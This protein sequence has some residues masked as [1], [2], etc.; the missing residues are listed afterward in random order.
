ML[1]TKHFS[2]KYLPNVKRGE[3][4]LGTLTKYKGDESAALHRMSDEL[5]GVSKT[6][7]TLVD[8]LDTQAGALPPALSDFR[9][10]IFGAGR[11]S[12]PPGARMVYEKEA[13]YFV[14]CYSKGPFD[15]NR[16]LNARDSGNADWDCF[17]VYDEQKLAK[18]IGLAARKSEDL[19]AICPPPESVW[20]NDIMYDK[21]TEEVE[22]SNHNKELRL[23]SDYDRAVDLT[24]RA[25]F[26]KPERFSHEEETRFVLSTRLPFEH[27]TP[28]TLKSFAIKRAILEVGYF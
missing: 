17:V 1:V 12:L 19:S 25:V 28:L 14:G 20:L 23:R 22:I 7:F 8:G 16:A 13:N 5:E 27:T 21:E 4:Q 15:L 11:L 3:A 2:K 9:N 26:H 18:A 6:R 10:N 24:K